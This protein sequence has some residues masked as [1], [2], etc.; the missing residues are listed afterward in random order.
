MTEVEKNILSV[1][2]IT[3]RIKSIL[4]RQLGS[5]W[6]EG[7]V[8]NCRLPASGHCYF[9]L[10]DSSAQISAVMFRGDRAPGLKIVDGTMVRVFGR[11]TVYERGGNYQILVKVLEEAGKGD[12]QKQFE[13]LKDK[14]R[15]EGLFE[16]SRK[17]SIPMLPQH[18][19]VV[20]S[21]TGAAIRDILNVISRRFPNLHILLA[22]VKVQGEGAAEEIAQAIDDLNKIPGLDV[23]IVGRG[24]GSIEDLWA[25]NEEPVARAIYR[26][27]IPV[28]SAVGHEIDFTIA[29]FTA[30]LRAPTP[31]AA[32]ELVVGCKDDFIRRINDLSS[33]MQRVLRQTVNEAAARLKNLEGSYVFREPSNLV[34][35]YTERLNAI[36]LELLN[37]LAGATREIDQRLDDS[38]HRIATAARVKCE[39]ALNLL[40]KAESALRVMNPTSVLRRGYSITKDSGGRCIS[41]PEGLRQGSKIVTILSRGEV[42]ST[43]D[44]VLT[45]TKDK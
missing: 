19:G 18:V 45:E 22:P 32:A 43:V 8:S 16:E 36:R 21:R 28:I 15:K 3:R 25:F 38:S 27:K 41:S 13:L 23:L 39:R 33:V 35:Q 9:T 31:S 14:L 17:K 1:S 4:E 20:T 44:K 42:L 12:L 5:V 29:D 34:R 6:V 40:S 2:E 24:G 10:K 26:S 11:V 30:D 7:E 37:Q